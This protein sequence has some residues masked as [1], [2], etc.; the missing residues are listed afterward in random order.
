MLQVWV[1]AQLVRRGAVES[2][3]EGIAYCRFRSKDG[4]VVAT[5]NERKIQEEGGNVLIPGACDDL[6]GEN[7]FIAVKPDYEPFLWGVHGRPRE[8]VLV[9]TAEVISR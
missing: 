3:S 1:N 9:P 6:I 2:D 4:D 8:T 5:F 7:G